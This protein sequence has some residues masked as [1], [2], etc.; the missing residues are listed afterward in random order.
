MLHYQI[1]PKKLNCGI[2]RVAL[3]HEC[4]KPL[5]E[6]VCRLIRD[7]RK[8]SADVKKNENHLLFDPTMV[9][10]LRSRS[11]NYRISQFVKSLLRRPLL[12]YSWKDHQWVDDGENH[13]MCR[14]DVCFSFYSHRRVFSFVHKW[15][16][17]RLTSQCKCMN[18]N[19]KPVLLS[20][21]C[22]TRMCS[23]ISLWS[24]GFFF[25][26]FLEIQ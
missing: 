25:V 9:A 8:N 11:H 4:I 2:H 14:C 3:S 18:F 6:S 16:W 17:A 13:W 26:N 7:D 19:S 24:V 5:R 12:R 23:D 10:S 21:Y 1:R 15:R 22:V 20:R